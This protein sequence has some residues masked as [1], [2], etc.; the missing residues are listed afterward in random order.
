[1]SKKCNRA[2]GR[3]ENIS[4]AQSTEQLHTF[5]SRMSA[6]TDTTGDHLLAG[7]RNLR[8]DCIPQQT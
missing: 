7:T 5:W 4:A 6:P 3:G 1:M 2:V 8:P